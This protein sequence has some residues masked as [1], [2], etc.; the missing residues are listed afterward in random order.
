[1]C[2]K[3]HAHWIPVAGIKESLTQKNFILHVYYIMAFSRQFADCDQSLR[4]SLT[5]NLGSQMRKTVK[6]M[7]EMMSVVTWDI[8]LLVKLKL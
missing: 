7:M 3:V 2:T 5:M 6:V 1:M 4:L 8:Q